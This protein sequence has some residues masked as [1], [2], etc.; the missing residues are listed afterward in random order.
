MGRKILFIL[1]LTASFA[2]GCE[3]FSDPSPDYTYSVPDSTHND[4]EVSSLA[5]EG[6]D[7]VLIIQMTN[8]IIREEYKRIDGLLILRNNKLVYEN[9][10][11]GYT[12]DI[13]HNIFSAGKS[14]TSILTGI[15]IDK[16]FISNVNVPVT[17][18]LPEYDSFENPD[19]RKDEITIEHLLN[20]SSGLDCEDWFQNTESQMQQSDDWVKFTFDL[21]IIN[22]PGSHGSYCTGCAVTLGRVIENQ[23]GM[24]LEAF[25][26]KYLFEPLHISSYQWHIMPDGRPSGGGL[27][28]LTPVDMAKVGLLMLNDGMYNGKQIVS[29]Q[30]VA[31]SSQKKVE[32]LAFDGYGY[33]WWKQAFLNDIETYFADGNGGQQ[34]F[35]VPSEELVIVFTGGNQNTAIGAQNFQIVN[36]YILK[37]IQ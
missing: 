6:I 33:L 25:A 14:I 26:S 29:A 10:F 37:A 22:D 17:P 27:L 36:N 19:P 13:L 2:V 8:R 15:A 7:E 20:M 34:I 12:H 32:L 21:P 18:L 11:H 28:F 3:K 24:S 23:S 9:Y 30:W 5:A 1:A 4:I 31:Q 16:G 35:I